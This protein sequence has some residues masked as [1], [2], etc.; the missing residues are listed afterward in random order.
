MKMQT[1]L[2]R[3]KPGDTGIINDIQCTHS[4]STDLMEMGLINGTPVRLVKFAPL[5]DPLEIQ[6]RGYHLSIRRSEA[7]SILVEKV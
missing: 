7:R 5:G 4:D 6:V 3:L 1:S 2:D